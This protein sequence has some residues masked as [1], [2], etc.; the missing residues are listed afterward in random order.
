MS[1]EIQKMLST[2]FNLTALQH[3][4]LLKNPKYAKLL[5]T[6]PDVYE[7]RRESVKFRHD[8]IEAAKR[9][10]YRNEYD[11]LFSDVASMTNPGLLRINH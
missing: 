5:R 8:M 4:K 10:N 7:R 9:A 2:S 6:I 11:R 1:S 3:S